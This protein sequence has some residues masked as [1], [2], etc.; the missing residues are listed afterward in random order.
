LE[1]QP[2]LATGNVSSK[3]TQSEFSL[4]GDEGQRRSSQPVIR[5]AVSETAVS[6][7]K[8]VETTAQTPAPQLPA[9]DVAPQA[10]QVSAPRRRGRPRKAVE[11]KPDGSGP[12]V[13][14]SAVSAPAKDA[15]DP[16]VVPVRRRGRPRKVV[17]A[18]STPESADSGE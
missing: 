14:V 13:S 6:A 18:S 5:P 17:E 7:P 4:S 2:D 1:P 16:V 3:A 11:T 9:P 15:N 8:P 10:G 12:D